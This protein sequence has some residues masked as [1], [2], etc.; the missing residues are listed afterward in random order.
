MKQIV[1]SGF[2]SIVLAKAMKISCSGILILAISLYIISDI[3]T[4]VASASVASAN[5]QLAVTNIQMTPGTIIQNTD[6]ATISF[7][8]HA[9]RA[10]ITID[11]YDPDKNLIRTLD[12]GTLE[13]GVNHVIWDC[14]DSA[15]NPVRPGLYTLEINAKAAYPTYSY[16][17]KWGGYGDGDGKLQNP[18]GITVDPSG[19]V[20]VA[21]YGNGRVQ[22]FGSGGN[23]IQKFGASDGSWKP[24]DLVADSDDT[25]YVT[26]ETEVRKC[27]SSG[28]SAG[29][30]FLFISGIIG[31]SSASISPNAVTT[32]PN[33]NLYITDGN[34]DRVLK[35]SATG[36][37]ITQWGSYGSGP[38]QFNQPGSVA[39][40]HAGNMYIMD[41]MNRRV[42]KFSPNGDYTEDWTGH[43]AGDGE[44]SAPAKI[45]VDSNGI[46]FVVDN[47]HWV[48]M[49]APD[50]Y[51]I[52]KFGGDGTGDGQF[53]WACDIAV[54]DEGYA[55]VTDYYAHR[56]QKFAPY[57]ATVISIA[58]FTVTGTQSGDQSTYQGH[59]SATPGTSSIIT[60]TGM[61]KSA[62]I[63]HISQPGIKGT[64]NLP[65]ATAT[66]T[67]TPTWKATTAQGSSISATATPAPTQGIG[68]I[69]P[70]SKVVPGM[71]SNPAIYLIRPVGNTSILSRN[72]SLIAPVDLPAPGDNSSPL[73]TDT[74]APV[75]AILVDLDKTNS[76]LARIT[77]N[78]SDEGG[79]GILKTVYSFDGASW[80]RYAGPFNVSIEDK[81]TV[82]ALS[83]DWAGNTETAKTANIGAVTGNEGNPTGLCAAIILPLLVVGVVAAGSRKK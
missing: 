3:L 22:K 4:G 75:T 64:A 39:V 37:Y 5:S 32:D 27:I 69:K 38:Y 77:L 36:D 41:L 57:Y 16:V 42:H 9:T 52:G 67:P 59:I 11:I 65:A 78:A 14:R 81:I 15:N 35:H 31:G 25:I 46:V 7:T 55:Y 71:K 17:H 1:K 70:G 68:L 45:A 48:K 8:L 34:N 26:D 12:A 19:E 60:P 82:Y 2:L 66:S 72:S 79:A 58:T 18:M 80:T 76:S 43:A 73:V 13:P 20:Y 53:T 51:Y 33:G 47:F 21:D 63:G 30:T 50:G 29:Y 44:L 40:D 74:I 24:T 61:N 23:F 49:Y 62:T 54:N 56:V 6:S 28:S 83:V 10:A